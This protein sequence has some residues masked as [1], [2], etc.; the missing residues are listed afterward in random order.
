MTRPT[1]F[2]PLAVNHIPPGPA[3][4]PEGKAESFASGYSV[5]LPERLILPILPPNSS[6]NHSEPSGAAAM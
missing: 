1:A 6:V 3:A 4:M 2:S 5:T